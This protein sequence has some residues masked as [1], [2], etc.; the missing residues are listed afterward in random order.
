[1]RRSFSR[2]ALVASTFLAINSSFAD[3]GEAE[4][5][6]SSGWEHYEFDSKGAGDSRLGV[7]NFD[8]INSIPDPINTWPITEEEMSM[9]KFTT[10]MNFSLE[11][12][13]F[14]DAKYNESQ[15]EVIY[16]HDPDSGIKDL[17]FKELRRYGKKYTLPGFKTWAQ[18][19]HPGM[20]QDVDD[21]GESLERFRDT[22]LTLQ[23]EQKETNNEGERFIAKR[24]RAYVSLEWDG[25]FGKVT[26]RNFTEWD[27][28][29]DLRFDGR[30]SG[31]AEYKGDFFGL[32]PYLDIDV[33]PMTG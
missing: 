18:K 25:T 1:M 9:I 16:N 12:D 33:E 14:P 13:S 17:V 31:G 11:I 22:R 26:Y 10:F 2:L 3:S 5:V 15:I 20:Y 21:L 6:D 23:K 7:I 4:E 27:A 24:I 30:V 8:F 19:N 29:F 32:S 28:E